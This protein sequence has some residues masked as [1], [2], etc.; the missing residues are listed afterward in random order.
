MISLV[1]NRQ[2]EDLDPTLDHSNDLFF[3]VYVSQVNLR[4]VQK[5]FYFYFP[6]LPEE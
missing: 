3:P 6:S 4:M 5:S 1:L 2:L